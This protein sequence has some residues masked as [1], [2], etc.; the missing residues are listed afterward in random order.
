MD[1]DLTARAREIGVILRWVLVWTQ[2]Y[3]TKTRRP[4]AP[5]LQVGPIRL[6]AAVLRPNVPPRGEDNQTVHRQQKRPG[7]PGLL[8]FLSIE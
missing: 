7:K 3:S 5:Y 4:R 6:D 8:I 1:T 2:I